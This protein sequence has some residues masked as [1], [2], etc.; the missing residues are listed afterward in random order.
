MAN[1]IFNS[2]R[3]LFSTAKIDWTGS[4]TTEWSN[5]K[6]KAALVN[7]T[8]GTGMSTYSPPS[9]PSTD[10]VAYVQGTSRNMKSDFG[11]GAALASTSLIRRADNSVITAELLNRS[12]IASSGALDADDITF[13]NVPT[14]VSY[15]DIE[16]IVLYLEDQTRLDGGGVAADVGDSWPV[17]VFLDTLTGGAMSIAPNGGDIV[18]QW[19]ASGIFRL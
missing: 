1:F 11:Y 9:D 6:I 8:G 3:K 13:D 2:A 15:G 4:T 7:K 5:Y 10:A 17:L 14:N 18:V 19:S 16:G 12:I